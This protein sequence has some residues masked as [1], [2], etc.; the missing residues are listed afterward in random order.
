ME[1]AKR[2]L[3]F[4][5]LPGA[6]ADHHSAI[7]RLGTNGSD[8]GGF[9]NSSLASDHDPPPVALL[10]SSEVLIGKR[11]CLVSSDQFTIHTSTVRNPAEKHPREN[12]SFCRSL[13]IS[14]PFP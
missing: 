6:L 2:G 5:E 9:A 4:S 8:Q 1:K 14:L 7:G 10:G 11:N 3:L 13:Q 12:T